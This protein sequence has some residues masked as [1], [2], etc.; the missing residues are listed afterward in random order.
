MSDDES[1]KPSEGELSPEELFRLAVENLEPSQIYRAKFQGQAAAPLPDEPAPPSDKSALPDESPAASAKEQ[2][3]ALRQVHETRDNAFFEQMVG[4]VE[5]LADRDKY[6]PPR[7]AHRAAETPEDEHHQSVE[8][9]LT[10]SL[11]RHGKGLNHIPTLIAS[12]RELLRQHRRYTSSHRVAELNVR[13]STAADA[14]VDLEE[15]VREHWKKGAP[16][17][18]II[19]GRGLRSEFEPVL[20]PAVLEWLET[21]GLPHVR[22]YAPLLNEAR[23]Y[24]SLV[25]ELKP[26]PES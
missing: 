26:P 7:G 25:V 21:K 17:I 5:P 15:F 12:Q 22:G 9:L 4:S 8:K 2:Q 19:H 6:R 13:G 14:L 23:D 20:K 16:F 18:K 1:E 10:P 11:P 24:G 3:E